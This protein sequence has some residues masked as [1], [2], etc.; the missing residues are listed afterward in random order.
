VPVRRFGC[1]QARTKNG[2]LNGTG[3]LV[4]V[5]VTVPG[6]PGVEVAVAVG[7]GVLVAVAVGIGVGVL[8]GAGVNV[9]CCGVAGGDGGGPDGVTATCGV[10]L[11][12]GVA[13]WGDTTTWILSTP[14]CGQTAL[15]ASPAGPNGWRYTSS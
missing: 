2:P 3:V 1:T 8:V 11:G 6:V 15:T 14:S 10:G 4:G 5:A 9:G 12:V 13:G 7:T